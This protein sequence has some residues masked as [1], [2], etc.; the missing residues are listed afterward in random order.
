MSVG[1]KEI[2][3]CNCKSFDIIFVNLAFC[4]VFLWLHQCIYQVD[5]LISF[6]CV[7]VSSDCF[8]RDQDLAGAEPCE[9]GEPAGS[10]LFQW[11]S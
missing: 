11:Y 7:S 10:L 2:H 5:L 8:A 1:V 3:L 4:C 6:S 9:C